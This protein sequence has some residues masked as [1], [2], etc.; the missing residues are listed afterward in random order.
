MIELSYV[1]DEYE[2]SPWFLTS[3]R[4]ADLGTFSGQT[5]GRYRCI[6]LNQLFEFSCGVCLSPSFPSEGRYVC[7]QLGRDSAWGP[8]LMGKKYSSRLTCRRCDRCR[9]WHRAGLDA[10]GLA[11]PG[12]AKSKR[13]KQIPDLQPKSRLLFVR[14]NVSQLEWGAKAPPSPLIP[15]P[16]VTQVKIL[17]CCLDVPYGPILCTRLG[18]GEHRRRRRRLHHDGGHCPV[19]RGGEALPIAL[20]PGF[21]APHRWDVGFGVQPSGISPYWW[22]FCVSL[23]VSCLGSCLVMP[24]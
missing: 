20:A 19:R 21:Q 22:I 13:K 14:T 23:C 17:T 10:I 15:I 2:Q 18:S 9:A 4:V 1:G 24:G 5:L 3:E 16:L 6:L 12:R 8:P 7:Q 11:M